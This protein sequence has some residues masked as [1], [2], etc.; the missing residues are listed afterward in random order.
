MEMKK[1][2]VAT[3]LLLICYRNDNGPKIPP[4]LG[5]NYKILFF[6]K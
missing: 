5:V 6:F 2:E 4:K 3:L 1:G